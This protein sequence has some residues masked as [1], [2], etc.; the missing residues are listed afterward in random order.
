MS[1]VLVIHLKNICR[2]WGDG[3]KLVNHKI[4]AESDFEH[5]NSIKY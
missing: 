3:S 1:Y 5:Q 4:A 2:G